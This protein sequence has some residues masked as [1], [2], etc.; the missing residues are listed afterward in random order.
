MQ[1]FS[2]LDAPWWLEGIGLWLIFTVVS[3]GFPHSELVQ[4]TIFQEPNQ[5]SEQAPASKA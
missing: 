2:G 1:V 5:P 3:E 4:S